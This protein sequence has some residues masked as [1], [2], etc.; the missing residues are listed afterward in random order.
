MGHNLWVIKIES[1]MALTVLDTL[2][3]KIA[4]NIQTFILIES[5]V[6]WVQTLN[7]VKCS[8]KLTKW[9]KLR[10]PS[11]Q[12]L[13]T[14][15]MRSFSLTNLLLWSNWEFQIIKLLFQ[16]LK[17]SKKLKRKINSDHLII[18]THSINQ[19]RKDHRLQWD[20]NRTFV[21]RGT[22]QALISPRSCQLFQQCHLSPKITLS[23]K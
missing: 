11:Y 20:W 2:A 6:I 8:L 22:N 21:P 7:L 3:E 12:A 23:E 9:N 19:I 14:L 13:L 15:T 10:F 16:I 5:Y 1:K 17:P 18:L 4:V